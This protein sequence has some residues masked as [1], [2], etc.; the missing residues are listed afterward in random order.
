M[1]MCFVHAY[2]FMRLPIVLEGA[3]IALPTSDVGNQL[4]TLIVSKSTTLSNDIDA[5]KLNKE[6]N[7]FQEI[8]TTT[9][10]TVL[11]TINDTSPVQCALRCKR[12]RGC[13]YIAFK[14]NCLLLGRA[15]N[16]TQLPSQLQMMSTVKFP[17]VQCLIFSFFLS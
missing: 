15:Q 13:V 3:M 8:P 12:K 10:N 1:K 5:A 2:L 7:Y 6:A 4:S 11:E 14:H 9:N 17:G 16:G